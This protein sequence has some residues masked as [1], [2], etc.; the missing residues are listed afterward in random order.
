MTRGSYEGW[1][2]DE[3]DRAVEMWLAGKSAGQIASVLGKSRSSVMSKISRLGLARHN[4]DALG[5]SGHSA[6]NPPMVKV[7]AAIPVSRDPCPR[8]GVRGDV[9]CKHTRY[10]MGFIQVGQLAA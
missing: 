5:L 6:F 10:P 9:G 4:L 8:C 2:G 3:Q 1:R 7:K